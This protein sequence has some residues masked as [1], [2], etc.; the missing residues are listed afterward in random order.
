MEI[1]FIAL[2]GLMLA[3]SQLAMGITNGDIK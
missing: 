2:L 3:G 1:A